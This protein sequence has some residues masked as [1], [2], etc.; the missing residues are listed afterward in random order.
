MKRKLL[1]VGTYGQRFI[2]SFVGKVLALDTAADVRNIEAENV[3]AVHL[4]L[5]WF[6]ELPKWIL[7][8]LLGASGTDGAALIEAYSFAIFETNRGLRVTVE[9]FVADAEILYVLISS[10]GGT[11]NGI[12]PH[13]VKLLRSLRPP[14]RI[15]YIHPMN[16]VVNPEKQLSRIRDF[17]F[18]GTS[19]PNESHVL[20]SND[21]TIESVLRCSPETFDGVEKIAVNIM[22]KGGV[23]CQ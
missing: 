14:C 5:D 3:K 18:L 19:G 15:V 9:K 16:V 4:V 10:G 6:L 13:L 23:A 12:Y 8:S 2:K 7:K 1:I 20:A 22:S 21:A 11:G 17:V